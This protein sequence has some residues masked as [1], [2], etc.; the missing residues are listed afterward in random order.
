MSYASRVSS[1]TKPAC[2]GDIND[3]DITTREC[4][5]CAFRHDCENTIHAKQTRYVPRTPTVPSMS[6]MYRQ[7]Q[8]PTVPGVPQRLIQPSVGSR[9]NANSSYNF[10][11]PLL[12]QF[13]FYTAMGCAEAVCVETQQLIISARD[14]Y[15]THIHDE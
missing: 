15:R 11:K 4:S 9:Y 12:E 14:N 6:T 3:Y 5:G 13:A 10:K 2:F 7:P 1:L 8:V